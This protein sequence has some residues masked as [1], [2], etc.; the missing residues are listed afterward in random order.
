[1][2]INAAGAKPRG[3]AE[4]DF[5]GRDS[6]PLGF[7]EDRAGASAAKTGNQGSTD[8]IFVSSCAVG[9]LEVVFGHAYT[10]MAS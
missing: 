6:N 3:R 10:Y 7:P 1:M 9:A 5:A 2:A 8:Q 4:F